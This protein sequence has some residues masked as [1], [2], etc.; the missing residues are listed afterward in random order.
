MAFCL[1]ASFTI[2]SMAV[3]SLASLKPNK[4]AGTVGNNLFTIIPSPYLK[5]GQTVTGNLPLAKKRPC[6]RSLAVVC[7]ISSSSYAATNT[8]ASHMFLMAA[9][10]DDDIDR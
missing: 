2:E 8:R 4:L 1:M 9:Y 3:V 10:E 5:E 7:V 6:R